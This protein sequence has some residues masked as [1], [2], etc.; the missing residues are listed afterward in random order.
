MHELALADAGI[1]YDRKRN[2]IGAIQVFEAPGVERTVGRLFELMAMNDQ[3]R[4]MINRGCSTEQ[5]RDSALQG[6]M[7]PLRIA[8]L[9]KIYQGVTTPAEVIR[10]TSIE[11]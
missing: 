1:D 10:E 9:K 8:G 3:L 11:A 6:G 2:D 5:L 7:E 4:D